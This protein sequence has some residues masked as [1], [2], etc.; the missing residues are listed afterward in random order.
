MDRS[1]IREEIE[2]T[3]YEAHRD[4]DKPVEALKTVEQLVEQLG[5]TAYMVRKCLDELIQLGI[6]VKHSKGGEPAAAIRVAAELTVSVMVLAGSLPA[7]RHRHME[8]KPEKV[9]MEMGKRWSP[10]S[11][12]WIR[13][14]DYGSAA[15]WVRPE[16]DGA[17]IAV[18]LGEYRED[19]SVAE[20]W[21]VRVRRGSD[22][23]DTIM[24]K[25]HRIRW[26]ANDDDPHDWRKVM[27]CEHRLVPAS[28]HGH[29]RENWNR[30]IWLD[31]L[32][33]RIQEAIGYP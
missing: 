26:A 32:P 9:V 21:V 8:A 19:Q 24:D 14:L 17:S 2:V 25:V 31:P 5:H 23:L 1:E 20:I 33:R 4:A 15:A 11:S 13:V 16:D 18:Y 30:R 6:V 3:L 7:G 27:S 12:E 10:G 22:L 28:H 29:P